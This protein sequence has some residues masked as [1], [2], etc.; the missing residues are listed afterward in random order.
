M[1]KVTALALLCL[2]TACSTRE[3]GPP[4]VTYDELR[5]RLTGLELQHGDDA[6]MLDDV[7]EIAR[8]L[9]SLPPSAANREEAQKLV[10]YIRAKRRLTEHTRTTPP[11]PEIRNPVHAGR[12]VMAGPPPKE[13]EQVR[14]VEEV[15]V[16][17]LR[18]E[19]VDA[20]GSCLVRQTWHKGERGGPTTEVFQVL[21]DCRGD[22]KPLV[23]TVAN[24]RVMGIR[25]GNVDYVMTEVHPDRHR[26]GR[27]VEPE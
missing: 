27:P 3:S 16:G 2:W 8:Q 11:P 6:Y 5:L 18:Q 26:R 10:A 19:L 21:P 17:T 22:L 23:F 25:P 9:E 12:V 14:K 20:Y 7:L 13:P 15:K 24:D 4:P 1:R